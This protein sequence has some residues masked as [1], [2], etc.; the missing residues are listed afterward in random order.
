MNGKSWYFH[1]CE[2]IK[3]RHRLFR[4]VL[5]DY[6]ELLLFFIEIKP[7]VLMLTAFLFY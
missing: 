3:A 7:Q 2:I 6:N 5:F 1:Q 4:A